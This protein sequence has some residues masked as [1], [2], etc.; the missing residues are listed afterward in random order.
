VSKEPSSPEIASNSASNSTDAKLRM[1]IIM[2]VCGC[3]KTEVGLQLA[4]L[5]GGRYLDADDFHSAEN[6]AKM[7]SG[8]PLVDA[9]RWPW[10]ARLRGD[11]IVPAIGD[12]SSAGPVILGCSALR[13]AYR[14]ALVAGLACELVWFV[15][16]SGSAE[17]ILER[18]RA[19]QG[20]Y[21]KEGMIASQF[22]IL[23]K[24]QADENAIEVSIEPAPDV[25]AS[26]IESELEQRIKSRLPGAGLAGESA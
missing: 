6:I 24:P 11:V 12:N 25:I 19:R 7:G 17:L 22:A 16:L 5:L 9:D 18:M 14:D 3:G 4:K 21:M 15:H 20:H 8:Q 2:G 26:N 10:L 13:R 23:E 1:I